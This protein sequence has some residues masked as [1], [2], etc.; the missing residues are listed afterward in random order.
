[1]PTQI[2]QIRET[3]KTE[4]TLQKAVLFF[5]TLLMFAAS[6]MY[7][8]YSKRHHVGDLIAPIFVNIEID[9]NYSTV[10]KIV[11]EPRAKLFV[12]QN[13]AFEETTIPIR[14]CVQKFMTMCKKYF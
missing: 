11:S 1:M 3:G 12:P 13:T 6:F 7:D 2:A 14:L 4:K 10:P 9:K 8:A 5:I